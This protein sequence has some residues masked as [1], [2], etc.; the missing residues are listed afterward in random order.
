M[1]VNSIAIVALLVGSAASADQFVVY[2]TNSAKGRI[3]HLID[4]SA[5]FET[6]PLPQDLGSIPSEVRGIVI[7]VADLN[8]PDVMSYAQDIFE[9]GETVAMV[10]A[11]PAKA[12]AMAEAIGF[13]LPVDL[14]SKMAF[15]ALRT[16]TD[17][18]RTLHRTH[19]LKPRSHSGAHSP[20]GMD[21]ADL[22]DTEFLVSSFVAQE[23]LY[24]PGDPQDNLTNLANSTYTTIAQ[25]GSNGAQLQLVNTVWATRSF[26]GN[27]VDFYYV[28][29]AVNLKTPTV[30]NLFVALAEA[31]ASNT[32]TSPPSGA[33]ADTP[34]VVQFDPGT[35][36]NVTTY[37]SGVSYTLGGQAGFAAGDG[38]SL[39]V[40]PS[41]SIDNSTSV[42]VPQ[43][44]INYA[45]DLAT[46]TATWQYLTDFPNPGTTY[47][48]TH[49]YIWSVPFCAYA[50]DQT[51]MKF[52]SYMGG[53]W[54]LAFPDGQ[55]DVAGTLTTSVPL[56]FNEYQLSA[57]VITGVSDATASP[58]QSIS[59][60]GEHFYLIDGVII[61]GNSI[62]P[63]LYNVCES[64]TKLCLVI[65]NDQPAGPDQS[66]VMNTAEGLSNDDVTINITAGAVGQCPADMNGDGVLDVL[67]FVAFQNVFAAQ[68]ALADCNGDGVFTVLDFVCFTEAFAAGC[69]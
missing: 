47:G 14:D 9:A 31:T 1:T 59:I 37:T 45:G 5:D 36:Q 54:E 62:D 52:T 50:Q 12:E 63:S 17:G 18:E 56:P 41:M 26:T 69:P 7:S 19:I 29:Q 11:Q 20:G 27:D 13:G 68:D 53:I 48:F 22:N 24:N 23:I 35:T 40:V 58:G 34:V 10:S 55:I 44:T 32:L 21:Q 38:A 43:T 66:I 8:K 57:P 4:A 2:V 60:T 65:P 33:C 51:I 25:T 16:D 3:S 30:T 67:D 49:H 6:G 46:G 15:V 61:G 39:D 64:N 42:S 28:Q